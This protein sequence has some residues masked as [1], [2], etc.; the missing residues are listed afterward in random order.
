M[1]E[2]IWNWCKNAW[3]WLNRF[4]KRLW[5]W[6]QGWWSKLKSFILDALKEFME[7]VILD[8]RQKGGKELWELIQKE[9]PNT[10]TLA[11]ID[12]IDNPDSKISLS[13]NSD[14][15]LGKV[16]NLDAHSSVSDQYDVAAEKNNGILRIN[17]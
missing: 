3:N 11:D 10:N 1:W 8:R 16:E 6:I 4:F 17:G 15:S 13:F 12:K 5:G 14:G 2:K 7:V 9:Q